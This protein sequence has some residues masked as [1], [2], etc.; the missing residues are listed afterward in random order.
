VI[1]CPAPRRRPS[2]DVSSMRGDHGVEVG[3]VAFGIHHR[4]SADRVGH[5]EIEKQTRAVPKPIKGFITPRNDAFYWPSTLSA[6]NLTRVF[7]HIK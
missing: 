3:Q 6:W 7:R 1:E 4:L 5:L 2:P